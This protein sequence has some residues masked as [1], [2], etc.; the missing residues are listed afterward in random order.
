MSGVVLNYTLL[1][2]SPMYDFGPT[3]GSSSSAALSGW[4]LNTASSF[5][6]GDPGA[7]L[8]LPFFYGNALS[9]FG[10]AGC[11]F[12]VSIDTETTSHSLASGLI[13]QQDLDLEFHNF[14][15]VVG[16]D[17]DANAEL[18]FDYAV[19]T[20]TYDLD[21]APT[22]VIYNSLT[23]A[24]A[25]SE[26]W[27]M[28]SN[29]SAQTNF[30]GASVALNFTGV[31]FAISGPSGTDSSAGEFGVYIDGL[32]TFIANNTIGIEST[33][34]YYLGGLNPADQHTLIIVND[35][36]TFALDSIVVWQTSAESVPSE[37]SST[38]SG[39]HSNVVKIVVPIVAVVA[40]VLG[41]VAVFWL[42]RRRMQRRRAP[43]L[44][45]PF[46]MRI[47]RTLGKQSPADT[48]ALENMPPNFK[49]D[50]KVDLSKMEAGASGAQSS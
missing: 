33:T 41:L 48:V 40:A 17:A 5:I 44:S 31:A 15:L 7:N 11:T 39:S 2:T 6:T 27:T 13:F 43:K 9:L 46:G 22:E 25:F 3:T 45:G 18:V 29:G 49:A 1:N 8:S 28:S 32:V 47:A 26:G 16:S 23:E 20:S 34:L 24:L 30:P 4:Q 42:R 35:N 10:S 36:A 38:T 21:E 12:D 19:I 50:S 37:A 14:T